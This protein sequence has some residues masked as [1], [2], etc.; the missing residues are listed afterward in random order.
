MN[1]VQVH[2]R[3][4]AL[5]DAALV[6]VPLAPLA[7][8]AVRLAV[9]SFSVT[10]NNITYAVVGDG[11]KYWDFFPAPAGL[12]IVPMWGH[13]QVIESRHPDIAAGERVYG[14]LPMASHLDVRPGK[15]L[16]R[17]GP[18]G[19]L[20]KFA[21]RC[22]H[23]LAALFGPVRLEEGHR[24]VGREEQ[25]RPRPRQRLPAAQRRA[26]F[27]MGD[28]HQ[29]RVHERG[30]EMAVQACQQFGIPREID[31][32]AAQHRQ[33]FKIV[34]ARDFVIKPACFDKPDIAL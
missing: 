23:Q 1:A 29:R 17:D 8:G 25:L 9:E 13:A 33:A 15:A 20:E 11:F 5:T 31:A 12:G 22:R 30:I 26:R 7:D 19:S 24:M 34:I 10:A 4:D 6:E 2:V 3:K 18:L 27:D 21:P 32:D 16:D 28:A 14:Y